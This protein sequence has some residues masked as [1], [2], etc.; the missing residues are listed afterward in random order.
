MNDTSE[1]FNEAEDAAP[2][3]VD[4]V[5]EG[6]DEYAFSSNDFTEWEYREIFEAKCFD[7][8]SKFT[9]E[10]LARFLKHQ[11]RKGFLKTFELASFGLGPLAARVL[12][13][14][15]LR[16]AGLRVLSIPGNAIGDKGARDISYL[17]TYSALVSID[18]STNRITD[19]GA[20]Q[21]FSALKNSKTVYYLNIGSASGVGRNSLGRASVVELV[22]VLTQN[23]VLSELNIQMSELFTETVAPLSSGLAANSGLK[24]LNLSDNNLLSRGIIRLFRYLRTSELTELYLSAT[25]LKDDIGPYIEAF[26]QTNRTLK[27]LDLS[28]NVLTNRFCSCIALP[29]ASGSTLEK[30]NLAKNPLG[31]RGI[32]V[33]G[34]ALRTNSFLKVLNVSGCQIE[35]MGFKEFCAELVSNTV[36]KELSISR[37]P[38]RDEGLSWLKAVLEEHPA[39]KTL[40]VELTEMDDSGARAIF[41]PIAKSLSMRKIS[42]R[43]NLI[44]DG[45]L[46]YKCV[47]ENQNLRVCD[48]NLNVIDYRLIVEIENGIEANLKRWKER[49]RRKCFVQAHSRTASHDELEVVR[50]SIAEERAIIKTLQ[51]ELAERREELEKTTVQKAE[52]YVNLE[53]RLNE[54]IEMSGQTTDEV[55]TEISSHLREV[56]QLESEVSGLQNRLARETETASKEAKAFAVLEQRITTSKSNWV[57]ELGDLSVSRQHAQTKY[58]DYKR[59]LIAAWQNAK[60]MAEAKAA[61]KLAAQQ[62]APAPAGKKKGKDKKR[63]K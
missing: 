24:I 42:V 38:L 19:A 59:N 7:S 39:L 47:A 55:R 54:L 20:A 34:P 31:G 29:L 6:Q 12:S 11:R 8:K 10:H 27:V 49:E 51:T 13:N 57:A 15:L 52:N 2:G 21:V 18:I 17:I 63:K 43:N 26:L 48:V 1:A 45:I 58:E 60:L 28:S 36:L 33:L 46:I 35:P 53:T 14:I 41:M 40:D 22:E 61:E 62:A 50:T 9:E 23:Q 3:P 25:H 56:E 37:N 44:H 30:L 5:A 32:A 4:P 16:H